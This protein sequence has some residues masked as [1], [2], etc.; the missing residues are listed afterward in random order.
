MGL[1]NPLKQT[2]VNPEGK[3][4]KVPKVSKGYFAMKRLFLAPELVNT[5]ERQEFRWNEPYKAKP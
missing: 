5:L 3:F 4:R 2:P 1:Q